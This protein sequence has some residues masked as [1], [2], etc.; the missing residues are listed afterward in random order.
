MNF[1]NN[2]LQFKTS[3][4]SKTKL[5][6]GNIKNN[7][8]SSMHLLGQKKISERSTDTELHKIL[9][10]YYRNSPDYEDLSDEQIKNDLINVYD[11]SIFLMNPKLHELY[12][13]KLNQTYKK[14]YLKTMEELD[15]YNL[16]DFVNL[17]LVA[18]ARTTAEIPE[19]LRKNHKNLKIKFEVARRNYIVP[20][21]DKDETKIL[22]VLKPSAQMNIFNYEKVVFLSPEI[23]SSLFS[24]RGLDFLESNIDK[25]NRSANE[26]LELML[27]FMIDH[28]YSDLHYYLHDR[29]NYGIQAR[30]NSDIYLLTSKMNMLTSE[31]L[32]QAL[33]GRMGEDRKTTKTTIS[34]KLTHMGTGGM[35]TFRIEMARQSKS[36]IN[37]AKIHYSVDIRL[38]SDV[39]FIKNFDNLGFGKRATEILKASAKSVG[40]GIFAFAGETN[41]GKST[42]LYATLYYL[43]NALTGMKGKQT[44]VITV[45][46]VKEYDIDG[47]IQ[48]DIT[49][50]EDTKDPLTL[51]KATQS[52]LRQDPDIISLGEIRSKDD[53]KAA[54]EIGTRGHPT[55]TTL[56]TNNSEEV[57]N[58]FE[59][60]GDVKR[61]FFAGAMRLILH[62]DLESSLCSSCK[63]AGCVKCGGTGEHGKIPIFDLVYF[64]PNAIDILK[65]DIYDFKTLQKENK[66]WRIT[67]KERAQ[68]L[69]E[70]GIISKDVYDKHSGENIEQLEKVFL[71]KKKTTI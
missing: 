34:K 69:Y 68:E 51:A 33:L 27:Q 30:K 59:N 7:Q 55:F 21:R 5:K 15:D 63:G 19:E 1:I 28:D 2:F 40:G 11:T 61:Q 39:S 37:S 4:S 43:S 14:V 66:I 53:F 24:V 25:N 67:K 50:T 31:K 42:A 58:A 32:T 8:A 71:D 48:Y 41:S 62:I 6:I 20:M 70:E 45:D 65:D 49:D 60:I 22:G 64:I 38:L 44:K 13:E 57:I 26:I 52:I 36:G 16:Q 29:S 12:V 23:I 35:R 54:I 17:E 47:F 3:V 10:Q 46:K 56:H 18:N 9:Y